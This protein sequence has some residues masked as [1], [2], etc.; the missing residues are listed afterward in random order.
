MEKP[1]IPSNMG[2]I[3]YHHM[4]MNDHTLDENLPVCPPAAPC[5]LPTTNAGVLDRLPLEIVHEILFELDLRTLVVLR[6][7]NRRGRELVGSLPQWNAISKHARNALRGILALETGG[8]I[9]CRHLYEKLCTSACEYCGDFGGYLYLITC[10]RVCF[11]CLSED[12]RYFPP[13]LTRAC[14][15]FG[16]KPATIKTLPRIKVLPGTYSPNALKAPSSIR[17]DYDPGRLRV[18]PL[19]WHLTPWVHGRHGKIRVGQ[20]GQKTAGIRSQGHSGTTG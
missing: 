1:S 8:W 16:L 14:S 18:R 5:Q 10:R 19:R 6:R 20:S 17:V 11:L 7:V 15:K 3:T 2:D 12:E 13:S 4:G 9:T